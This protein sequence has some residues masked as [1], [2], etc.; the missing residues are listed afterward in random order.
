MS[1]HKFELFK[2][3]AIKVT[4]HFMGSFP[5]EEEPIF[6]S[7]FTLLII[8]CGSSKQEFIDEEGEE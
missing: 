7:I 3:N 6:L 5:G 4:Q 8:F 2:L 1:K